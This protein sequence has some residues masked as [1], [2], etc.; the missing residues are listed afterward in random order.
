VGATL[1]GVRAFGQDAEASSLKGITR[2]Q[3]VIEEISRDAERAG[4]TKA[5]LQ[6]DVELWLRQ[7]GITIDSRAPE[8]FY[9]NVDTANNSTGGYAYGVD[10]GFR[11]PAT[12]QRTGKTVLA[13][14]WSDGTVGSINSAK[15]ASTVRDKL[16]ELLDGFIK[17]Y[18]AANP[19]R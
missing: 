18:V 3:I 12:L 7:K 13:D 1:C 9:V 4:L 14:T 8:Q 11:Q 15:L 2:V 5:Q 17:E 10:V 6:S 16:R 19:K